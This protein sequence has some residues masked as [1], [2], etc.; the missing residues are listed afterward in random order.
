M[1]IQYQFEIQFNCISYFIKLCSAY[2]LAKH[3]SE[4]FK[5]IK[6]INS[7]ILLVKALKALEAIEVWL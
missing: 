2:S 6:N 3:Y 7:F 4:T 5:D 1:D